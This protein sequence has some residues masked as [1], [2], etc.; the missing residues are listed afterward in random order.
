M[1]SWKNALKS[2]RKIH[3][4]RAQPAARKRLGLLQ[5]HKDYVLRARNYHKK[6]DLLKILREKA[7]NRNPDEFYYR[8]I[9]QKTTEG[10]HVIDADEKLS[11]DELKL[12]RTQDL[13]YVHFKQAAEKRKIERLRAEVQLIGSFYQSYCV[14]S[15]SNNS[16]FRMFQNDVEKDPFLE[17]LKK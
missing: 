5:K 2:H 6:Q 13:R 1:S 17:I 15:T 14:V 7:Q 12:V 8:M 4:E 16:V 3:K 10:K 11:K 9:S